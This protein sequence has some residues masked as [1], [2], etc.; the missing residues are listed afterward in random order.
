MRMSGA[1]RIG[2]RGSERANIGGEEG[3]E[4]KKRGLKFQSFLM[5]EPN[6]P[7]FQV[8][9]SCYRMGWNCETFP[10]R[11][12]MDMPSWRKNSEDV[13]PVYFSMLPSTSANSLQKSG[14]HWPSCLGGICSWWKSP[15]F[16]SW[17]QGLQSPGS[18]LWWSIWSSIEHWC[19]RAFC[20]GLT[21]F[22]L[23]FFV[24]GLWI[25]YCST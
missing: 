16:I 21:I 22:L 2:V 20:L 19:G 23:N 15:G 25:R 8:L 14:S 6:W 18:F 24:R 9:K 1:Q 4:A 10:W 12:K 13:F 5:F 7:F 11:K 17:R 3:Q